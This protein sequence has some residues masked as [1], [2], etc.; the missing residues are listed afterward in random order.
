M[1]GELELRVCTTYPFPS[2]NCLLVKDYPPPTTDPC[3]QQRSTAQRS[4]A[5]V[6]HW[7]VAKTGVYHLLWCCYWALLH[8]TRYQIGL[9]CRIHY[10][11][12]RLESL[13]STGF[14]ALLSIVL[15]GGL[16]FA[17]LCTMLEIIDLSILPI[18]FGR[19]D[20]FKS[21][22]LTIVTS[23]EKLLP[24]LFFCFS[25]ECL[26]LRFSAKTFDWRRIL[27]TYLNRWSTFNEN[28]FCATELL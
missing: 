7:V 25:K 12:R 13:C 16:L 26:S 6:C 5:I 2:R 1:N 27:T 17:F 8:S 20:T 22:S 24:L 28:Y 4:L 21:S 18:F 11:I 23:Y 9:L 14:A 15:I 10:G 3:S 19:L